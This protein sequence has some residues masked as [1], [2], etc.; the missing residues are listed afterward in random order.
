MNPYN[1]AVLDLKIHIDIKEI[2]KGLKDNIRQKII[3]MV[4]NRC[5]EHGI[6]KVSSIRIIS[7]SAGNVNGDKILFHVIFE[8]QICS[9]V[10]GMVLEAKV[11]TITKAGIHAIVEDE[12]EGT[13]PIT[14]FVARDHHQGDKYFKNITEG[15]IITVRVI[16]ARFEL[17]DSYI[18]VIGFLEKNE[19]ETKQ[20]NN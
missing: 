4:E 16:G 10:E 12:E 20:I 19:E 7:H 17:N 5:I 14:V 1:H 8:C 11:M 13:S 6:V 3:N 9:P 15:S 2:G 18:C